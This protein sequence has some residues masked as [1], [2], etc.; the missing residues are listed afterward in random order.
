MLIPDGRTICDELWPTA[1]LLIWRI[2]YDAS[3]QALSSLDCKK[4]HAS[5]EANST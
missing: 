3:V 5:I 4:G 1:G 2:R